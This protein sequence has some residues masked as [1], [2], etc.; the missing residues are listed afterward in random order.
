MNMASKDCL[1]SPVLLD[2]ELLNLKQG[3]EFIVGAADILDLQNCTLG[4]EV[5]PWLGSLRKEAGRSSKE[6]GP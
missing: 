4:S 2:F 5:A 6:K 3:P 1:L